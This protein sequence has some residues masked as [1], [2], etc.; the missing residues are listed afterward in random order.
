MVENDHSP[1]GG[2]DDTNVGPPGAIVG[3]FV[4]RLSMSQSIFYFRDTMMIHFHYIRHLMPI[5][6]VVLMSLTACN[7][8]LI[9]LAK[10]SPKCVLCALVDSQDDPGRVAD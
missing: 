1:T 2:S 8:R 9:D 5:I 10:P 3:A 4:Y 6:V 7:Q